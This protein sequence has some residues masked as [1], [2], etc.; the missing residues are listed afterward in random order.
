[1]TKKLLLGAAIGC[2]L[3]FMGCTTGEDN[4]E[5][6]LVTLSKSI[7]YDVTISNAK[8]IRETT[9]ERSS[10]W[11]RNN[12]E[13][14]TRIPYLDMLLARVES[15]SMKI[16]DTNGN[17]VDSAH[18]KSLF[19]AYDT[20]AFTKAYPPYDIYDTVLVVKT[21]KPNNVLALRFKE[22][23]TYD[24]A[25]MAISKK[26]IAVAP[27]V[28]PITVDPETGLEIIGDGKVAFWI[29]FEEDA[30][31]SYTLTN[32]IMYG[33]NFKKGRSSF[34]ENADSVAID[35]YFETLYQRL[36]SDSSMSCY[37]YNKLD[38]ADSL[39]D[40][41][42]LKNIIEAATKNKISKLAT[43][44]FIEEWTFDYTT[45]ALSKKVVGVCPVYSIYNE[46]GDFTG[47]KSIFWVYFGE[48]WMPF[49][50][51]LELKK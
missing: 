10:R 20:V 43:I 15:G 33:V 5:S 18:V 29:T 19:Y 14:S 50:G 36:Y 37:D 30:L 3:C 12:I 40:T 51:K 25:T 35:A 27:I 48:V 31:P 9:V 49:N 23:W 24:P 2:A 47:F 38:M 41:K 46:D 45:L 32:R 26:I 17:I 1:M 44:R 22:D 7:E 11:F 8:R 34:A 42:E 13:M 16:T 21:I 28:M 39:I 4:K 6:K